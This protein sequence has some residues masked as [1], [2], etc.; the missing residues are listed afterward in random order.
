MFRTIR[1]R[2]RLW[3]LIR[4]FRKLI[5]ATTETAEAF[6]RLKIEVSYSTDA[7]YGMWP[8]NKLNRVDVP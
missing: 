6:E 2:Y 7:L 1:N 5:R 3:R 4:A 8:E